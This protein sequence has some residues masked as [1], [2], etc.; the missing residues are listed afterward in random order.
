MN[1]GNCRIFHLR[2]RDEDLDFE[3]LK[4]ERIPPHPSYV[5]DWWLLRKDEDSGG[6]LI[7]RAIRDDSSTI[8]VEVRFDDDPTVCTYRAE[9]E[10]EPSLSIEEIEGD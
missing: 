6:E 5:I 10:Y 7:R 9:I 8:F 3:T 4:Y 1:R 2:L